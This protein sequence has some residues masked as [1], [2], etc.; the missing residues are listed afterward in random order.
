MLVLTT[1]LSGCHL[2][3]NSS[4]PMDG[5]SAQVRVI[6]APQ[7]LYGTVIWYQDNFVVE[8]YANR[9]DP[10]FTGRLWSL[11]KDGTDLKE[12]PIPLLDG[13]ER[14]KVSDPL[15]LLNGSLA[16][17]NDCLLPD[18]HV[19]QLSMHSYDFASKQTTP[20]LGY[21]LPFVQSPSGGYSFRP[22]MTYGITSDGNGVTLEE[23]MYWLR[24]DGAEKIDLGFP[25][26]WGGEFRPDGEMIAF[27]AA[28]EQGRS[29]VARLD[30]VY[31]L[32]LMDAEGQN[33][34][35][36]VKHLRHPAGPAW[37]PDGQWIAFRSERTG[38]PFQEGIWLVHVDTGE[39][40]L[41]VRGSF[42]KP[43]WSPNGEEIVAV[44]YSNDPYAETSVLTLIKVAR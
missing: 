10:W 17:I 33:V 19:P 22:D 32:Y 11:Q 27:L 40:K 12:L 29:G 9:S 5:I 16:Y 39:T 41:L 25:Q 34:R 38:I 4:S 23:Q 24:P 28:P 15:L 36:L 14:G 21:I 6:N 43:S 1:L 26:A 35:P 3:G 8:Y 42:G 30:S 31:N 13:C 44:R 18:K 2:F 20:L 7:G 37:S